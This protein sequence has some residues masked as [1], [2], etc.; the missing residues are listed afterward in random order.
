MSDEP[1]NDEWRGKMLL[2]KR[3]IFE[4]TKALGGMLSAEHGVGYSQKSYMNIF[5]D[6]IYFTILRGVKKAFDPRGILNPKKI[7]D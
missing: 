7:F 3:E 2:A 5:F 1:L 6:E 4:L